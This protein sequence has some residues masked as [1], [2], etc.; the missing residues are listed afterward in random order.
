[1]FSEDIQKKNTDREIEGNV[2]KRLHLIT[3]RKHMSLLLA[4][5]KNN[6]YSKSTNIPKSGYNSKE[7]IKECL[8]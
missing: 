5:K 2:L 3:K 1:M 7:V 6:V 8:I 4:H